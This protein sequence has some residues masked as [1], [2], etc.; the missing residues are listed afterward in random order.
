[1][2]VSQTRSAPACGCLCLMIPVCRS[3]LRAC[4]FP[5][6]C[7]VPQGTLS[8][9]AHVP[10]FSEC[11]IPCVSD[12]NSPKCLRA[13]SVLQLQWAV[14]LGPLS[15]CLSVSDTGSCT[16]G[17]CF[18]QGQQLLCPRPC[19]SVPVTV[20]VSVTV[21]VTYLS[22][23]HPCLYIH[24]TRPHGPQTAV[25]DTCLEPMCC[26]CRVAPTETQLQTPV[27]AH[28]TAPC[29]SI[30]LSR[31]QAHLRLVCL[32]DGDT[33]CT[34]LRCPSHALL[35]VLQPLSAVQGDSEGTGL[36]WGAR[37]ACV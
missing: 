25:T 19:H 6:D 33:A 26:D 12:G 4:P 5:S 22:T 27:R 18:S 16:S 13:T 21:T 9:P 1:M 28:L 7:H 34:P 20:L 17:L 32:P 23:T 24:V 15:A 30:C 35:S 31:P 11:A 29:L 10:G 36:A 14:F 8:V 37:C 2:C 3:S